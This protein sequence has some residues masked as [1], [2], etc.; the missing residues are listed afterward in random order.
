MTLQ[1]FKPQYSC[2]AS[3]TITTLTTLEVT[4]PFL[5]PA[6]SLSGI[7]ITSGSFVPVLGG[8]FLTRF[9][10]CFLANC[11]VLDVGIDCVVDPLIQIEHN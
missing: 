8:S 9:S 11:R 5:L 3:S 1:N 6:D 4:L 10:G 2:I 7:L